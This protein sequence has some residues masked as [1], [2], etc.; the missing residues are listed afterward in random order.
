[1]WRHLYEDAGEALF[2]EALYEASRSSPGVPTL[3]YVDAIIKR[4]LKDGVT[5]GRWKDGKGHNVRGSPMA[6]VDAAIEEYG[7]QE[8]ARNGDG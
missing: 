6:A 8:R 4:C 7:R 5:P 2:T 1:M 3:R